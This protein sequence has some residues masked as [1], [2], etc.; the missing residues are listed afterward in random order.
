MEHFRFASKLKR[1]KP[2]FTNRRKRLVNMFPY[3][4]YLL[5]AMAL[6]LQG[7]AF[8]LA[9][10]NVSRKLFT[11]F[12][13]YSVLLGGAFLSGL[14]AN[15]PQ[16]AESANQ[17]RFFSQLA[18]FFFLAEFT[19][20]YLKLR[21]K[22]KIICYLALAAAVLPPLW[23][24]RETAKAEV[25]SLYLIALPFLPFSA[26]VLWR[27]G[28]LYR[29]YEAAFKIAAI[30]HLGNGTA[31]LSTYF[32]IFRNLP[33][34]LRIDQ[35]T[36]LILIGF[37][38]LC[39]FFCSMCFLRVLKS[40]DF[41]TAKIKMFT[42]ALIPAAFLVF[43]AGGVFIPQAFL[44]YGEEVAYA[45]VRDNAE[46][47][48]KDLIVSINR[49]EQYAKE[50]AQDKA[51]RKILKN[52]QLNSN[53][54]GEEN[55]LEKFTTS[56]LQIICYLLNPK[57]LCIDT[58]NKSASLYNLIGQ[59]ISFAE[60]FRQ[61]MRSGY[62]KTLAPGAITGL[63]GIFAAVRVDDEQGKPLGVVVARRNISFALDKFT[64]SYAAVISPENTVFFTNSD[65][66]PSKLIKWENGLR[67]FCMEG[68]LDK[69]RYA[70]G[71]IFT[72]LSCTFLTVPGW[73]LVLGMPTYQPLFS[74]LAGQFFLLLLW[75]LIL[76]VIGIYIIQLKMRIQLLKHSSWRDTVFNNNTAGIIVAD[77][78]RNVIDA[79][80]TVTK[81]LGY[82]VD[83]LKKLG[84]EVIYPND[85]VGHAFLETVSRTFSEGGTYESPDICLRRKNGSQAVFRIAGNCFHNQSATV[86]LPR[87]GIVWTITDQMKELLE[88]SSLKEKEKMYQALVESTTEHIFMLDSHGFL[89]YSNSKQ[90]QSIMN[91]NT[92]PVHLR[93]VYDS[94][95]TALYMKML[96]NVFTGGHQLSF[97]HT[98]KT[99]GSKILIMDV[100]YPIRK[101][102]IIYA[103]GG[104]ARDITSFRVQGTSLE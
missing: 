25:I 99:P 32:L 45:R 27:A 96:E 54:L 68:N 57:G 92:A 66:L 104:I 75:I 91:G 52:G 98:I 43:A 64:N 93:D 82:T 103:A 21:L 33:R 97:Q 80:A 95:T 59:D 42:Y 51:I 41:P 4:L 26:V 69:E 23:L 1:D 7:G 14:F 55:I 37:S 81:L 28:N 63:P 10:I 8:F 84:I 85:S 11:P 48:M 29:K 100:L 18:A 94:S 72:E 79:N 15:I 40:L 58:S 3:Y 35:E 90:I 86:G 9:A 53:P 36:G 6:F 73:R 34:D 78:D 50:L 62:S 12:I 17:I 61:A 31:I 89:L 22:T 65:R 74:Y 39:T 102:G 20:A 44:F 24:V 76:C 83:D 88:I 2:F 38:F 67:W 49:V 30:F 19:F 46:L 77:M 87:R 47:L 13:L 16:L 71:L 70:N 60:Y 5:L 101:D 56:Q